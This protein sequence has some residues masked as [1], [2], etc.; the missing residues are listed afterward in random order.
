MID[1]ELEQL[2]LDVEDVKLEITGGVPTWRALPAYGAQRRID[3][4]RASIRPNDAPHG[5]GCHH[6]SDVL[7]RFSSDL[8]RRPDIAIWCVEPPESWGALDVVPAAVVEL[9]SLPRTRGKKKDVEELPPLYIAAGVLD[10]IALDPRTNE[11][12]HFD[13]D[14]RRG[15]TA[16]ITLALHC[17]CLIDI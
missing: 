17:G 3:R 14:G 13:A 9:I 2:L 7:I 16:P 12:W 1:H 11:I 4:I 15:Y 5:C 10:V 6:A 8:L